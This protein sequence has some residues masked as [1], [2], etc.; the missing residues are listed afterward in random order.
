MKVKVWERIR[1][2]VKAEFADAGITRCEQCSSGMFLGFAHRYKRRMI[3]TEDEMRI[4]A[5]LCTKCHEM[6][7]FSGHENMKNA[8]DAIIEARDVTF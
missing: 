1:R 2:Q 4:V 8:I 6:I 3:T 5:L 7:E